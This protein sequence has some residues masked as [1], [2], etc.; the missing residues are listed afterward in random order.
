MTHRFAANGAEP[1]DPGL[2]NPTR[3]ELPRHFHRSNSGIRPNL[4][5][6]NFQNP[7]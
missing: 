5:I 2:I 3:L 4:F 6:T 7:Q 1:H